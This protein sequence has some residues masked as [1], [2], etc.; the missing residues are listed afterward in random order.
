L[1]H[2]AEL[3]PEYLNK[4]LMWSIYGFMALTG[5]S[6][7][8]G[9]WRALMLTGFCGYGLQVTANIQFKSQEQEADILALSNDYCSIDDIKI[10]IKEHEYDFY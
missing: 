2:V 6:I 5:Y 8:K 10:V 3:N 1:D 9:S 7:V 4:K